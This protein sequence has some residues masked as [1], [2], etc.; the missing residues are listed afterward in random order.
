MLVKTT[1]S[2]DANKPSWKKHGTKLD[3]YSR[4]I[5]AWKRKRKNNKNELRERDERNE[6]ERNNLR[7]MRVGTEVSCSRASVLSRSWHFWPSI[8]SLFLVTFFLRSRL[9]FFFFFS[10]SSFFFVLFLF[11]AFFLLLLLLNPKKREN[12]KKKETIIKT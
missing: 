2:L 12:K 4:T 5:T 6:T 7:Y 10:G 11:Y 8:V 1:N 9:L 3:G